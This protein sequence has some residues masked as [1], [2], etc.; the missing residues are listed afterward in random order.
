MAQVGKVIYNL[1]RFH[2]AIIPGIAVLWRWRIFEKGLQPRSCGPTKCGSLAVLLPSWFLQRPWDKF[3]LACFVLSPLDANTCQTVPNFHI[4]FDLFI[5]GCSLH[6]RLTRNGLI[7]WKVL[8]TWW[9]SNR[10]AADS[11]GG[12]VKA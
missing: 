9:F 4:T 10:H 11:P 7:G 1:M 8:V 6:Y 5:P 3:R 12:R 2:L